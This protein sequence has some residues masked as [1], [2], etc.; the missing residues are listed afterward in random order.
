M[1]VAGSWVAGSTAFE[2]IDTFQVII[3]NGGSGGIRISDSVV[4]PSGD[5][6]LQGNGDQHVYDLD[7]VWIASPPM[8]N[9]LWPGLG[10]DGYH[11]I[12]SVATMRNSTLLGTVHQN[13][14]VATSGS[15]LYG[16]S[17]VSDAGGN[18]VLS[19]MPA[20]PPV[21]SHEAL[22]TVWHS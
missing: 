13:Y 8:A 2:H 22:D 1:D 3:L 14:P 5:K 19:V 11:A 7:N 17:G 4:W 18:T 6:A 15:E 9:Q 12:T 16:V 20:P 10:L 21:P